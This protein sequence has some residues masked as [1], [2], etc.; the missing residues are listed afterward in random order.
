VQG[1]RRERCIYKFIFIYRERE[2]MLYHDE[3][4]RRKEKRDRKRVL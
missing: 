2:S 4:G 1:R 3:R